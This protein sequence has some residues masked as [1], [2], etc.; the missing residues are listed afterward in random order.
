MDPELSLERNGTRM[1]H[2][3]LAPPRHIKYSDGRKHRFSQTILFRLLWSNQIRVIRVIRG[4]FFSLVS[5]DKF[6]LKIIE[7]KDEEK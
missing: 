7:A 4:L 2:A 3:R 6:G 5:S 1:I